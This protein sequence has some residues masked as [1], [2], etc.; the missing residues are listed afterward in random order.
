VFTKFDD[1]GVSKYLE[2][3]IRSFA[4]ITFKQARMLIFIQYRKS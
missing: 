1:N 3:K 4:A 2:S